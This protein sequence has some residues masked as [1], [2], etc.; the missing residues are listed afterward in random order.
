MPTYRHQFAISLGLALACALTVLGFWQALSGPFLLDDAVH[1]PKLAGQDGD[2]D[3]PI[4]V[5]EL[6]FTH[7]SP[8][9]RPLSFLTLLIND[10]A[11]PAE[12]RDFKYT[13]LLIHALNGLLVF[14]LV[15]MMA[16]LALSRQKPDLVYSGTQDWIALLV[17]SAWLL[18]PIQLSPTMMVIQRM[19]LLM[20]TFCFLGLILYL[21]GRMIAAE[22]PL[23]GY[24]VMSL[25]IGGGGILGVLCKETAVMMV[26]YVVA[27]ELTLLSGARHPRPK[28]WNWWYSVFILAPLLLVAV[29]FA[30]HLGRIE[31]L[32]VKR[33]FD[34]VERLLTQ[35]RVLMTYLR[36]IL[37]PT[38]SGSG[39]YQD[40]FEISR[41]LFDPATTILAV[42]SASGLIIG[43]YILRRLAPVL[44]LAILWFFLGHLLESTVLPLELYFEHRNYVPMIGILFAPAYFAATAPRKRMVAAGSAGIVCFLALELAVSYQSSRV[45]GSA[46][47]IANVWAAEHPASLRAQLDAVKYSLE[48][49][50]IKRVRSLLEAAIETNPADAGLYLYGFTIDRCSGDRFPSLGY[51]LSKLEEVVPVANFE[52]ASLSAVDFLL[53]NRK[54]GRCNISEDE[55]LRITDLYLTNPRFSRVSHA[56]SVLNKV[57][58]DIFA[59]QRKL[60]PTIDALDASYAAFPRYSTALNQAYLLMTAGL[61][62]EARRYILIARQT[63][64]YTPWVRL[65]QDAEIDKLENVIVAASS[66]GAADSKN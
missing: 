26:C 46:A 27:L 48:Q 14:L 42:A 17:A 30:T 51:T 7:S 3:T 2:I 56:S 20:G 8:T 54:S 39:P 16:R 55:L 5:L 11:W 44:S 52:H 43:A 19:T 50:D 41:G 10:N 58:A 34:V 45:W 23:K 62:E 38:L 35:A 32:Y 37:F 28:G 36:V 6:V 65:W 9:G 40:D 31:E 22:N 57:R 59:S 25:G 21:K 33:E 60:G 53:R 61:Y 66:S 15:R 4:E 29:Y 64:P 13:N 18:H 24:V 47:L 1:L 12:P 49:G 63:K